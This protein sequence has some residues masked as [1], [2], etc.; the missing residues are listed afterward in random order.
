M[1]PKGFQIKLTKFM[2]QVNKKLAEYLSVLRGEM[3][4]YDV[5]KATG[6]ARSML[7]RYEQGTRIPSNPNLMKLALFYN[8]SY[9]VLKML[10]LEDLYPENSQE[11]AILFEWVNQKRMLS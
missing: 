3:S 6:I 1:E 5:E 8:V 4:R 2:E 10:I 7:G 9:D 11:R